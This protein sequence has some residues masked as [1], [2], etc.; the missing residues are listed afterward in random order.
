MQLQFYGTQKN[1]TAPEVVKAWIADADLETL[2]EK[3]GAPVLAAT[4]AV[5]LTKSQLSRLR[6]QLKVILKA[7]EEAFLNGNSNIFDQ[8]RSVA[9]GMSQDPNAFSVKPG[10]NLVESGALE[11]IL[12][13]LPYSSPIVALRPEHWEGMSIGERDTFIRRLKGLIALYDEYDRDATHWE[14]FGSR[15]P[16]DWVYRVPLSV[17][18]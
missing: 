8:L 18:P 6:Q 15:N 4:P 17:L 10:Q 5:L 9:A 14:S 1:K 2:E 7:S 3:N 16:D 12:A 13:D 11:E